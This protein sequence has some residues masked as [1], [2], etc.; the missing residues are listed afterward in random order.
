MFIGLAGIELIGPEVHLGNGI[1][2]RPTYAHRFSAANFA[3][4]APRTLG[5]HHPGPWLSFPQPG[6]RD[7]LAELVIPE[8][9]S[10]TEETQRSA[11]RTIITLLRLWYHP[12][13]EAAYESNVATSE[14]AS[15]NPSAMLRVFEQRRKFVQYE[16]QVDDCRPQTVDRLAWV[17][18]SWEAAMLKRRQSPAFDLLLEAFDASQIMPNKSMMLVTMWG[19]LE[20]LFTSEKSELRFRLSCNMAAYLE[21]PGRARAELQKK[22][23]KLYDARSAAA[24]G[25]LKFSDGAVADSIDLYRRVLFKLIDEGVVPDRAHLERCLFEG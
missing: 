14:L 20:A 4:S 6:A 10:R 24:H 19:A 23:A 3:F 9:Y 18:E 12:E 1:V 25:N 16:V 22:V 7:V 15:G 8:S 2:L 11:S 21:P 17:V 13:V 5:E